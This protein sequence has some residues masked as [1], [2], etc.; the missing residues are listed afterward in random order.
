MP[1]SGDAFAL[2]GRIADF[3]GDPPGRQVFQNV[4]AQPGRLFL[5]PHVDAQQ[6]AQR[7]QGQDGPDDSE[8]ISQRIARR[9]IRRIGSGMQIAES[10]LRGAQTGRIGDGARHHADHRAHRKARQIIKDDRRDDPERDDQGG[11]LVQRDAALTERGEKTRSD[12]QADR[13]DEENQSEFLEEV[14]QMLVDVHAETAESDTDEQNA[15]H[16]QRHPGDPDL[17]Q[18]DAE[19]YDQRQ[20]HHRVGDAAA[21][22]RIGAKQQTF[23]QFHTESRFYAGPPPQSETLCRKSTMHPAIGPDSKYIRQ[24]TTEIK[25]PSLGVL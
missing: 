1:Y 12:L 25:R 9:N 16:A 21:P 19:G 13:I 8:R 5:L 11:Q 4:R 18:H 20:N 15:R 6:I 17:A 24:Y 7:Q 14:H 22:K 23:D 10:L 2:D 3:D